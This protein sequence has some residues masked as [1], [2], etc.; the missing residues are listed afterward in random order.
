MEPGALAPIAIAKD[1]VDLYG[2]SSTQ[3]TIG[4]SYHYPNSMAGQW[5]SLTTVANDVPFIRDLIEH[6]NPNPISTGD[7]IWIEPGVKNTLYEN[8]NQPS[9]QHN[10]AGKTIILPVVDAIINDTTHGWI[11]VY[12]FVGFH[13][14]YAVGKNDKIIVGHF[15]TNIFTGL[16][17][18]AGPNFGIYVPP[19]LV[20]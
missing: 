4:S 18:P 14:D 16:G 20:R 11:P 5:T 1:V 10:Y 6:G 2:N 13:V 17:G 15:V 19:R 7:N 9:I 8:G 12:G 3:I